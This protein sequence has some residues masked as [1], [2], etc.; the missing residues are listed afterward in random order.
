MQQ[1][2]PE[3]VSA[4]PSGRVPLWVWL[5]LAALLGGVIGLG[6]YTF[7][8]AEGAS[9]LVDDPDACVNCHIMRDQFDGWNHSVHKNVAGCNDCHAP[10]DNLISKYAVK[11]INGFRHSLMFTTGAFEEPI[12]ITEMNRNVTEHACLYCHADVTVAMNHAGTE[13]P[14]DCLSCHEGIGHGR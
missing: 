8:Y 11:G 6:A 4:R 3:P 1:T 12:R 13:D 14:T 2:V 5:A 10:H 9:Y 7:A